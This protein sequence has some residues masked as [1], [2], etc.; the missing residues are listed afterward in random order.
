[1]NI[2]KTP[3]TMLMC[4]MLILACMAGMGWNTNNPDIFGV[5]L[6]LTSICAVLRLVLTDRRE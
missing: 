4:W 6:T 5:Y 2:K 1:M 3:S